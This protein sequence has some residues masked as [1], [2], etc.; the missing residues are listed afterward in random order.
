MDLFEFLRVCGEE[1]ELDG[2]E[3][4]DLHLPSSEPE[5]LREIKR[6]CVAHQ[7]T[8]AGVAVS[9]DFGVRERRDGERLR[10]QQWCDVAAYLGAPIVRVFA[11]WMP[12]AEQPRSDGMIVGFVR[13]IMGPMRQDPRRTWSDVAETLR[14]CADYAG[15][16]GVTIALQNTRSDGIVGSALQLAQLVRD[17]GSPWLKVCLD[18]ADL[19][20][21]AGIDLVLPQTVQAHARLRSVAADG[22]DDRIAWPLLLRALHLGRYR[23]FLLLDY[24]GAEDPSTAIPRAT[25]YL[26]G[27]LHLMARQRVLEEAAV[28]DSGGVPEGM[29]HGVDG[30]PA[31]RRADAESSLASS[32]SR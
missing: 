15:D 1:L 28:A 8:L 18:P 7:L 10:V 16:R 27:L 4:V 21:G 6:R 5:A 12:P 2:V 19:S 26:R 30:R 29:A 3:L 20:E 13:R 22:A 17:V 9:N 32:A 14:Q 23:G 25:V 11:G 24:D 31:D